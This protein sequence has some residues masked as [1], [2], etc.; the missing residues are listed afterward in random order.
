MKK[1]CVSNSLLVCSTL[2]F[3]KRQ[4]RSGPHWTDVSGGIDS[5]LVLGRDGPSKKLSGSI[6]V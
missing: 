2:R 1:N 6:E 3:Q 5:A 4:L